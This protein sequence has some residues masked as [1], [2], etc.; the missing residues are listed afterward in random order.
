MDNR[1]AN[2]LMNRGKLSA[3]RIIYT[4]EVW[5]IRGRP[6]SNDW[7]LKGMV[8]L[9]WFWLGEGDTLQAAVKEASEKFQPVQVR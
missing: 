3:L 2:R 9:E 7:P 6:V 8:A 1:T 4:G 5:Q